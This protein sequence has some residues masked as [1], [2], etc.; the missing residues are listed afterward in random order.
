M[1]SLQANPRVVLG[2][3][4]TPDPERAGTQIFDLPPALHSAPHAVADTPEALLGLHRYQWYSYPVA[5][6]MLPR[7]C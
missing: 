1:A 4:L 6:R 5:D 2:S 7:L 3:N